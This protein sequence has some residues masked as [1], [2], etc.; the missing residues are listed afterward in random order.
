MQR[1]VYAMATCV[2]A[3]ACALAA[4]CGSERVEPAPPTEQA[5]PEIATPAPAALPRLTRQQY[6]NVVLD[7][8][9]PEIVPPSALEPD[10]ESR[11]SRAAR[12]RLVGDLAPRIGAL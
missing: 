1:S 4:G 12:R 7:L 3:I 6:H 2:A 8:F 5:A 10:V 11:G 9:G